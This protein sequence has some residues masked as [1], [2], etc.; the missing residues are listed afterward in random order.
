MMS[1]DVEYDD[2]TRTVFEIPADDVLRGLPPE[3]IEAD[4]ESVEYSKGAVEQDAG[5]PVNFR[6][7]PIGEPQK[8]RTKYYV[9]D[10]DGGRRF[11]VGYVQPYGSR[12]G[13]AR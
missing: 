6:V 3:E 5:T 13:I 9:V 2:G 11:Y 1:P 12:I 4:H 10:E 7:E 8:R